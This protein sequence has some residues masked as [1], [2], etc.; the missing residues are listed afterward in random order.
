MMKISLILEAVN[1]A[2]GPIREVVA[3]L[4]RMGRAGVASARR[5][6][7]SMMYM[8]DQVIDATHHFRRL[9]GPEGIARA[10]RSIDYLK[11]QVSGLTGGL[12]LM[13]YAAGAAIVGLG[14]EFVRGVFKA[15]G[16]T[17]QML[18][19][20]K[21]F[22][23]GA[24]QAQKAMSWMQNFGMGAGA[25]FS[26]PDIM[27]SYQMAKNFGMNPQGGS[28]T[29]FADLAAGERV[30]LKQ[31]L[32]AV[33]DAME[34]TSTRPIANL[35]IK[36]KQGKGHGP[37]S[38]LY[39]DL[40]G[41]WHT[42]HSAKTPE[43][44]L[45]ALIKIINSKYIGMA[46][47]QAKTVP[48]GIEQLHKL[49]YI[50]ESMVASSGVFDWALKKINELLTW[51]RKAAEDGSLQKFAK[52]ISDF[53]T[54]S[55]DK[56]I[57]FVKQTDWSSV[58]RNIQGLAMA[59]VALAAPL[60]VLANL[61]GG[62]L[63]GL[64]NLWIASKVIGITRALMGFWPVLRA[65]ASMLRILAPLFVWL[66]DAILALFT[67]MNP[68]AWIIASIVA[69]GI[70]GVLL[71]RNWST[72]S[73]ALARI[74]RSLPLPLQVGL[75]AVNPLIGN[76]VQ[77]ALMIRRAWAPLTAFFTRLWN[78]I[79]NSFST[80]IP[81]VWNAIPSWMRSL[82]GGAAGAVFGPTGAAIGAALGG[83]DGR[84]P[85]HPKPPPPK[86]D[87]GGHV[88][89][90][91]RGDHRDARVTKLQATNPKVGLSVKRG[92]VMPGG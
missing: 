32:I 77:L 82:L 88:V 21:R 33:K 40:A 78:G 70:A 69:L 51:F 3:A 29:A 30:P 56:L 15:G 24:R 48:G 34:G 72:V 92:P 49:L 16:E 22:E 37:N 10:G 84:P 66:A 2:T 31:V 59:L 62:G 9:A 8:R 14:E 55:G 11:R 58:A 74:W 60:Q 64:L 53:I 12:T 83:A 73:K 38:Y 39:S 71:W 68:I 50:F 45:A 7:S 20:L 63:S 87:V 5:V 17:E 57:A 47:A 36:M 6:A 81:K 80:G 79:A 18:V 65:G 35:G 89:I 25:A 28:L 44:T 75:A 42:D 19:T 1:R 85:T 4:E 76:F 52:R 43:A 86:H 41:K 27:R 46:T 54:G 26:M 91:L 90:E 23:G 61:G 13:K 67:A